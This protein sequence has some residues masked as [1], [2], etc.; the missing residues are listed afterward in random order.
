MKQSLGAKVRRSSSTS[1][2]SVISY[3]KGWGALRYATNAAALNMFYAEWLMQLPS[4]AKNVTAYAAQL[5][6][7]VRPICSSP[8]TS[9]Y[10]RTAS[11]QF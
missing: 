4:P 9:K 10:L 7:Y 11:C 8:C 6:N 2:V 1:E 3:L 5:F